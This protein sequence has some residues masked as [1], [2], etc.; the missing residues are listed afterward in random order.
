MP[1]YSIRLKSH[2]S[3]GAYC[4]KLLTDVNNKLVRFASF[5]RCSF[6]ELI[7]TVCEQGIRLTSLYYKTFSQCSLLLRPV[8]EIFTI[9]VVF[10][11]FKL[12]RLAT[13]ICYEILRRQLMLLYSKLVCSSIP[14]ISTLRSRI[15]VEKVWFLRQY[16]S[17]VQPFYERAVSNLD[18]SL[19]ISLWVQV[20]HSSFIEGLHTTKN[21]ASVLR[22]V[23]L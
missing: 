7:K 22:W 23:S 15:C 17:C 8:F 6:Y 14:C 12:V 19:H 2:S 3:P 20:A 21:M 11:Y 16:F 5:M 9:L 10:K 4:I 18:S 13:G 1:F